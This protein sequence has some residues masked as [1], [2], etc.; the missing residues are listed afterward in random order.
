MVVIQNET[1]FLIYLYAKKIS[2]IIGV[3][4]CVYVV[5]YVAG[6][7]EYQPET[8]KVILN[9]PSSILQRS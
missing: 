3:S 8:I 2:I 6:L 4:L 1:K 9:D 7:A 5:G